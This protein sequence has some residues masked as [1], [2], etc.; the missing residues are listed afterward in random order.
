MTMTASGQISMSGLRDEFGTHI[1]SLSQLYYSRAPAQDTNKSLGVT[2]ANIPASG[3]ISFSSFYS[4]SYKYLELYQSAAAYTYTY[5]YT[6]PTGPCNEPQTQYA[7]AYVPATYS[8]RV[9][10]LSTTVRS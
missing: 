7:T 6:T 3:Q 9:A 10:V 5:S 4:K 1:N 8:Y 2:D